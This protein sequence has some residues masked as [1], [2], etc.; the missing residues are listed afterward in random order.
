VNFQG[1]QSFHIISFYPK[2]FTDLL[3]YGKNIG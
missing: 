2:A 1:L 3:S